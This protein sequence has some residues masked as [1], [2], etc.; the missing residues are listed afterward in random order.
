[1][2]E[3]TARRV[4]VQHEIA[5]CITEIDRGDY[6][7]QDH[8]DTV[9]DLSADVAWEVAQGAE[10]LRDAL[11]HLA[12]ECQSWLEDMAREEAR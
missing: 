1:M 9:M 2:A 11:V 3:D 5:N 6:D 4:T 12:A 8:A 7:S 10:N